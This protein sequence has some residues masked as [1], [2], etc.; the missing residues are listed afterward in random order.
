M[1]TYYIHGM[2]D[3][4][5]ETIDKL[6][7]RVNDITQDY[8]HIPLSYGHVSTLEAWRGLKYGTNPHVPSELAQRIGEHV[9][10]NTEDGC[11]VAVHSLGAIAIWAAMWQG[12]EFDNVFVFAGALDEDRLWPAQG[13]N[14]LWNFH[15]KDDRALKFADG[16]TFSNFGGLGKYGYVGGADSR[17]HNVQC[18]PMTPDPDEWMHSFYFKEPDID[19]YAGFIAEILTTDD[20]TPI[21][22]NFSI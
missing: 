5:D 14:N 4:G 18:W 8:A 6:A 12:R 13:F 20:D 3:D 21:A 2:A 22:N 11:N 15:C 9:Y 1:N 16:V 7:E 10:D 19:K 17:I